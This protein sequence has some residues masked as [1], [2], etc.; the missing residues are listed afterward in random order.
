MAA[1]EISFLTGPLFGAVWQ[2]SDQ[3]ARHQ[4]QTRYYH[5]VNPDGNTRRRAPFA[6]VILQQDLSFGFR[7]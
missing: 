1:A 3:A 5:G 6:P 2:R 4:E 7:T